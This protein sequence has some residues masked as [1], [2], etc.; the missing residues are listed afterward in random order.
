MKLS[1]ASLTEVTMAGRL[2]LLTTSW[3]P[4]RLEFLRITTERFVLQPVPVYQSEV[5]S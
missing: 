4:L 5:E 2:G 3:N 1:R